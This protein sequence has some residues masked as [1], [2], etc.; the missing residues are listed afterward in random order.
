MFGQVEEFRLSA[1]VD[2]HPVLGHESSRP[3]AAE[4][5]SPR[6]AIPFPHPFVVFPDHALGDDF[7]GYTSHELVQYD[8]P[9]LVIL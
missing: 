7:E 9:A 6:P 4:H 2:Q 1:P 8:A 5:L 3:P